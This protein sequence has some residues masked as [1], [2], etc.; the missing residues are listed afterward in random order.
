MAQRSWWSG[1]ELA[2]NPRRAVQRKM[3]LIT[4]AVGRKAL[5]VYPKK[6]G[7]KEMPERRAVD[8]ET[9]RQVLKKP[10]RSG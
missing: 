9:R 7:R 10:N 4:K 2:Q 5:E 1:E 8:R 6:K 3:V